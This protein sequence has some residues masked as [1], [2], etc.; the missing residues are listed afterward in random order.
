MTNEELFAKLRERVRPVLADNPIEAG[1]K[2]GV[3][4]LT[5]SRLDELEL[6]LVK[7]AHAAARS[8]RAISPGM[9]ADERRL[10]LIAA[11]LVDP[12]SMGEGE[13]PVPRYTLEE[14][15]AM[16]A[17]ERAKLEALVEERGHIPGPSKLPPQ[18]MP[19]ANQRLLAELLVPRTGAA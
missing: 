2:V 14:L 11:S 7:D 6:A 15:R 19:E 12:A 18:E 4:M 9:L 3:R 17:E 10:R 16:P 13:R 5:G 8:G 1:A